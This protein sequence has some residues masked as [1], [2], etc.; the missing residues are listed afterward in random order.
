MTLPNSGWLTPHPDPK[1]DLDSSVRWGISDAVLG[2]LIAQ[3]AALIGGVL[4]LTWLGYAN[5]DAI[6]TAPLTVI[7]LLQIPLWL[8]YGGVPLWVSRTKGHGV[9]AD[10]GWRFRKRDVPYGLGIGA[11]TQF[12][13]V[14]LLYIPIFL[15]FGERDV[16]EA[17]RELTE[18]ATRPIDVVVL[19]LVVVVG[20][21]V[22][23][24]L[25]FRGLLLRSLERR[26]GSSWA[27]GLS[28]FVF[29]VVHLQVLQFPALMMFGL[30]AAWM[31]VRSGRLGPAIWTH[32]GFN[33]VTVIALLVTSS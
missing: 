2:F 8:G 1:T 22:I 20:A 29:G 10:F 6:S 21:P 9:V 11:L 31:T 27:I 28:S 33:L 25:F 19:L 18:R 3:A 13:L 17:A 16:S 14:P 12:L 7:F 4:V 5:S 23:E 24:E 15:I 26:L 32:V 30:I